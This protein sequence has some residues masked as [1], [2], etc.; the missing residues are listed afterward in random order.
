MAASKVRPINIAKFC[1]CMRESPVL[2]AAAT[3]VT[4]I[5]IA[6]CKP[7]AQA[8]PP[9]VSSTCLG[10]FVFGAD[11]SQVHRWSGVA[12]LQHFQMLHH[13][14]GHRQVAEPLVVRWDHVPGGLNGAA[15]G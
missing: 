14:A 8:R 15:S 12:H 6:Y 10:C 1:I 9:A 4:T 7:A 2:V 11:P 13:D 5:P 3:P